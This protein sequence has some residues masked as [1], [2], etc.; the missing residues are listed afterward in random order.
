MTDAPYD[1]EVPHTGL[2]HWY[3]ERWAAEQPTATAY[4]Y[5]PVAMTDGNATEGTWKE[6]NREAARLA[7]SLSKAGVEAGDYVATLFPQCPQ[8]LRTYAAVAKLGA[9]LVPIDL[10]SE[11][12][13]IKYVLEQTQPTAFL[14]VDAYHG[15]SYRDALTG[16][17][18]LADVS[19]VE[20]FDD[21]GFVSS[22]DPEEYEWCV[23]DS[24]GSTRESADV[25][26]NGDS[27]RPFLVVFT[28][29]TTGRPKGALLSH[30]NAVFQGTA[31]AETWAIDQS[32]TTLVH[33]PP[34]HVGGSTELLGTV[35]VSGGEAVLLDAFD[36]NDALDRIRM[37]SITVVGNVPAMWEMLFAVPDHEDAMESVETAVV[38]GQAPSENCL[39]G[40]AAIGTPVTGWGLTE[41]GGFV[42]LTELEASWE[43]LT[44]TVGKPYS[45]F[46]VKAVD[47]SGDTLPKGE[48]GELVVRGDGVMV[49]YLDNEQTAAEM[50]DEEWIRTGDM[51]FV[52]EDGYVR[53]RGRA[54]NMYISGGYNV[55][56]D[57]I[58]D[59]LTSHPDVQLAQV[60][61]IEHEKWG[62]AGHAFIVP[63]PDVDFDV[64]DLEEYASEV[65]ADYKRPVK[66]TI[67]DELPM[68]P[69]GKIDRQGLID[70]YDLST[71]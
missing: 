24:D 45:G 50:I 25:V 67:S 68:T 61:G 44:D 40:M 7:A 29:G 39:N 49:G 33:L 62:E 18:L 63:E 11:P 51:G 5:E 16:H 60:V 4:S 32:D 59:V 2:V 21:T 14:G 58:E 56:P 30:R 17:D 70:R 23:V 28:S 12:R 37:E 54:H 47:E 53:L 55:Y 31:M 57:E 34:S 9:T 52:D 10:R 69:L 6:L 71:A 27:D 26:G 66:Y 1:P 43:V 35:F 15:E 41:T 13:E 36:P 22:G 64:S 42:T 20:W 19:I 46:D 8:Y 38:A 65:L 48:T 3:L